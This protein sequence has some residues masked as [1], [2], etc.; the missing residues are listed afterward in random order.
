VV[1]RIIAAS[2]RATITQRERIF[3]VA[4]QLGYSGPNIAGSSLRLGR[5]GTVGVLVPGSLANT[6]EDPSTAML[7]RGIV[8][9]GE[10][11]DVALTLLPVNGA[12][13]DNPHDPTKPAALRG[14]VDGVVMH[15][16]PNDHP[17]VETI[18]TRR[19]PAVAIDSPRLPGVPYV[20]VDHLAAAADQINYILGLGHRRIAVIAD[21]LSRRAVPGL[22]PLPDVETITET[23][24]RERVTGYRGVVT[25]ANL[26]GLD[27]VLVEAADID[28]QSGT[29][30]ATEI[31]E[32]FLP[33]AIIATS[34]T[35]AVAAMK[36]LAKYSFSVP[37]D[38]SVIGFDDAPVADL[39]GLT[40]IRQPLRE[41]GKAAAEILLDLIAGRPRRRSIR[42]TE[43]IV[44]SSTGPVP[45][46]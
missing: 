5:I 40:T 41:K 39:M 37:G 28:M 6:V 16:L 27:V 17:A 42:P 31:I 25:D 35:H 12:A 9:V 43:L 33:R 14:L 34:D 30:A 22:G 20:T 36:V 15:C 10:L 2:S 3:A 4:A 11:A 46:A 7:L 26:A 29:R 32:G 45:G 19:I 13:R 23:Y 8:E 1:I 18:R 38:V 44:R 24:L 21:R